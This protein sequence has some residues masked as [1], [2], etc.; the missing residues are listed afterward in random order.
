MIVEDITNSVFIKL[1]PESERDMAASDDCTISYCIE[2]INRL[3]TIAYEEYRGDEI[4][5]NMIN[6]FSTFNNRIR[7]NNIKAFIDDNGKINFET[8]EDQITFKLKYL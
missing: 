3:E 5:G 8:E 6:H 4:R 7:E 1:V 2:L